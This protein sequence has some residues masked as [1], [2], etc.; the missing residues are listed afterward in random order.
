MK[1]IAGTGSIAVAALVLAIAAYRWLDTPAP[2]AYVKSTPPVT[3]VPS[4]SAIPTP[5]DMYDVMGTLTFH[6]R[7]IPAARLA[8]GE[9]DLINWIDDSGLHMNEIRPAE[10][11]PSSTNSLSD[12]LRGA[13]V[14]HALLVPPST[15]LY[16]IVPLA[17]SP[18]RNVC[19]TN[20][21]GRLVSYHLSVAGR[22]T[23]F[24]YADALYFATFRGALI[25]TTNGDA[26]RRLQQVGASPVPCNT[27]GQ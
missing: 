10:G 17:A 11:W 12:M 22:T 19:P 21:G 5:I 4:A 18:N 26:T 3:T 8:P 16:D 2:S 20:N 13:A 9:T 1:R 15:V 23:T 27:K 25:I 24:D 6:G 14:L 7:S